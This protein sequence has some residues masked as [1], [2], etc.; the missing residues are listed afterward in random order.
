MRRRDFIAIGPAILAA[1]NL[2]R[3]QQPRKVWR[4]GIIAGGTRTSAYD[5]FLQGM[6]ELG[7]AEGVDYVTDWRFADGRYARFSVFAEEFV[8]RKT[9]VIFIG[10][11]A[12]VDLVRQVTRA[13]PIVMGYS[14]DPVAAGYVASLARP[15]GNVTGLASPP[16]DLVARHFELLA[17][18][19]PG[20]KRV[21]VL[22]N[23]ES[24]DYSDVLLQLQATAEKAGLVMTSADA[25]M[26]A[27][28]DR[29]FAT[30]AEQRVQAIKVVDDLFFA[31]QQQRLA[32]FS[33]EHRL[34]AIFPDRE[35]VQAGGLM[36]YGENLREFYR[37]AA[38]Y[39]DRIL[40]GM[41]AG[42]LPIEQ[43]PRQ[44]A[45]NRKAAIALGL[46]IPP[47]LLAAASEVME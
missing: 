33:L 24:S 3:A 1:P 44:I 16:D 25:R 5:G 22:L 36:S 37:R 34:P 19:V 18:V 10:T 20:L 42:D 17:T 27:G 39:V 8:Q 28:I 12:A 47:A 38:S 15:G 31:T 6:R 30:F 45:I 14:T 23:P 35:Y 9:D 11:A 46:T 32:A 2:A 26:P 21:G 41:R 40:N 4:V 29:A 13:I 7:H 43:P